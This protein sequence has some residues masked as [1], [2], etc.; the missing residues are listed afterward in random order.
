MNQTGE[1]KKRK[2]EKKNHRANFYDRVTLA[3]KAS[4]SISLLLALKAGKN[5]VVPARFF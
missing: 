4:V 3:D 2:K 1:K 5:R